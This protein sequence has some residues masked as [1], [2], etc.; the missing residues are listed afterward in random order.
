MAGGS[1]PQDEDSVLDSPSQGSGS[2]E[3]PENPQKKMKLYFD[4]QNNLL[5]RIEEL[6]KDKLVSVQELKDKVRT[7][8]TQTNLSISLILLTLDELARISHSEADTFEE[9]ARQAAMHYDKI[10]IT[11]LCLSVLGGQASD[12]ISKAMR[13]FMK[14]KKLGNKDPTD[15]KKARFTARVSAY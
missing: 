8:C 7:L 5:K 2:S 1:G 11:S 6:E 15:G 10:D 9:L 12:A 4:V 14:E 3:E 13:K